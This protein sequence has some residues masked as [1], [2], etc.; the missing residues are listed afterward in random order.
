MKTDCDDIID[1]EYVARLARLYLSEEEKRLF[2]QQLSDIV[3]YVRE[4]EQVDVD[5][6]EPTVHAVPV[7]NMFRADEC[8]KG[9]EREVV[10]A[11]APE[12]DDQQVIVPRMV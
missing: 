8:R 2:Q 5:N 6:V 9:L 12:H 4:I 7:H 10:L 1:V 11:N 3:R